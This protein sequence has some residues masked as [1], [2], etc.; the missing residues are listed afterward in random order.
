MGDPGGGRKCAQWARAKPFQCKEMKETDLESPEGIGEL[1]FASFE[2][3]WGS[4]RSGRG[5]ASRAGLSAAQLSAQEA[6][7]LCTQGTVPARARRSTKG[8][9]GGKFQGPEARCC[10]CA[11]ARWKPA[12][13]T[14]EPR[15]RLPLCGVALGSGSSPRRGRA[16]LSSAQLSSAGRV[17]GVPIATPQEQGS[18]SGSNGAENGQRWQGE[19]QIICFAF[20]I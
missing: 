11:S 9:L 14:G 7:E 4:G 16:K 8:R 18:G 5:G 6:G 12:A 2:P 1:S 17:H 13:G 10:P 3:L 15:R 19:P 20:C